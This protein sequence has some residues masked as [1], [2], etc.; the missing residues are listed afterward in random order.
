MPELLMSD[1]VSLHYE[2]AGQ[3][4]PL[5]LIAGFSS[6]SASWTP[7]VPL[8]QDQFTLIM[9]DNRTTGRTKPW[10]AKV[11]LA[12]Y[13]SDCLALLHH[14]DFGPAHVV[15]H[16]MGGMVALALAG[17]AAPGSV[18]RVS[19]MASAPRSMPRNVALFHALL[20]IRDTPGARSDLWLQAFYPW[21]FKPSVFDQP[22]VLKQ[23]A[24]MALAYPYLQSS[25]AMRHQLQ[26]L[27][28]FDFSAM[29]RDLDIPMQALIAEHDLLISDADMRAI[30]PDFAD[31]AF[32][33]VKDAGHSL[34]WDQP[35]AVAD[36]IRAFHHGALG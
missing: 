9:P 27:G 21:L 29:K 31:M 34:H 2:V 13:A 22:D 11:G 26:G 4:P 19:I 8:L 3:G 12:E 20:D 24:E 14:L 17:Q 7:L 28:G 23:A 36:L 15:G 33:I 10:N 5:L 30:L 25:E 32:H 35:E 18:A 1:D 6:D 16:S